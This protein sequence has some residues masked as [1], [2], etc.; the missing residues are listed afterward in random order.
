MASKWGLLRLAT[1]AVTALTLAGCGGVVPSGALSVQD[2]EFNADTSN[3]EFIGPVEAIASDAWTIG[4]V[5]VGLTADTEIDSG[6]A[7]GDLA[8]VEATVTADA[9]VTARQIKAVETDTVSTPDAGSGT[10]VEFI[11]VVGSIGDASWTVD[12]KAVAV[13]TATEIKDA[14]VVGD[15]V[16]VH[17]S[18]QADGS[19]LAT[20]IKLAEDSNGDGAEDEDGMLPD[21]LHFFG[22]VEDM[23]ADHWVV[24]GT[25][26]LI[27]PDTEIKDTIVV[28]DFVKVEATQDASGAYVAQE[29]EL[30]DQGQDMNSDGQGDD[31][32]GDEGSS[33]EST[34]FSGQV[35]AMN[36]DNWVVG[37]M[38]F[39]ITSSTEIK[40]IIVVGDFVKI[41][42]TV[43]TDG[44]MTAL[45]IELDDDQ[46]IGDDQESEDDH[47]GG[48]DQES[49]DDSSDDSD[50]SG[51]SGSGGDD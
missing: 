41:E 14:I 12:D 46:K 3:I 51:S 24:G 27:T 33:S 2:V 7:I 35:T 18:L 44:T 45:E 28:G 20:E 26:F 11:G 49:E 38:T 1:V 31:S 37:G 25:T 48:D 10:E 5:P 42:A 13:D 43:A 4:G 34:E 9:T 15:T 39:L 29:I 17:A 47:S 6:L 50:H 21:E 30:E 22:A 19:L 36:A 32:S 23:Q 8:K 16:K 40:D